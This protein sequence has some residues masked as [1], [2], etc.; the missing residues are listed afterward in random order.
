ME[1]WKIFPSSSHQKSSGRLED[2]PIIFPSEIEWMIGRSF[3]LPITVVATVTRCRRRCFLLPVRAYTSL[4]C[5]V[6][7][8]RSATAHLLVACLD[9]PFE[10]AV[11]PPKTILWCLD[12]VF[13]VLR[14]IGFYALQYYF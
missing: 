1:D 3:H 6:P 7:E 13:T 10:G 11:K 14:K 8:D 5:S 9:F 4:L 12:F 2:L